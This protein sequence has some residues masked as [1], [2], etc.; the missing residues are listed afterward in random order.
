MSLPTPGSPM[1][2]FFKDLKERRLAQVT[3]TYLAVAWVVLQ[4]VDI[5]G[6]QW[7]WSQSLQQSIS[8]LLGFG[9][10]IILLIGWFHGE[11]GRQAVRRGVVL[12]AVGLTLVGAVVAFWFAPLL[13]LAPDNPADEASLAEDSALPGRVGEQAVDS[14]SILSPGR[15]LALGDSLGLTWEA[16]GVLVSP[17]LIWTSG[18]PSIVQVGANGVVR[19]ISEGETVVTAQAGEH[20]ARVA[21]Q[22]A[23]AVLETPASEP[24]STLSLQLNPQGLNLTSGDS[25]RV[26]VEAR[27]PSGRPITVSPV[28][29]RSMTPS[30]AS[31]SEDGTVRAL[32]V[33]EATIEAIARGTRLSLIVNVRPLPVTRMEL[34]VPLEPLTV[35]DEASLRAIPRGSD[36]SWLSDRHV[37]WRF[38]DPSV[39]TVSSAGVLVALSPGRGEVSAESEGISA[40]TA[41]LVE[42]ARVD[43]G[44]TLPDQTGGIEAAIERYRQAL[45]AGDV[46]AVKRIYPDLPSGQEVAWKALFALGGIEVTF[47]G[48]EVLEWNALTARARFEQRITGDRIEPNTTLFTANLVRGPDGWRI[49]SLR[50]G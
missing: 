50:S 20:R 9:F 16:F 45:E 48:V 30:V 37:V 24:S 1:G 27:D 21:I 14:L 23:R 29:W 4:V 15:P 10:L 11:R 31:V 8:V 43:P 18:D 13:W 22:V 26:S 7:N 28:Q 32:E 46:N 39:A 36:G 41:I 44:E 35:G 42:S 12:A 33:G 5:L 40:S 49:G 38:S 3:V 6:D 19:G 25:S 17:D 34:Q 47:R 2:S